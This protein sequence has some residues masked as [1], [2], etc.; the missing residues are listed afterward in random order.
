MVSVMSN[1]I[2]TQ[3][4]NLLLEYFSIYESLVQLKSQCFQLMSSGYYEFDLARH[5]NSHNPNFRIDSS[6]YIGREISPTKLITRKD[7]I[8]QLQNISIDDP[9]DNNNDN[10]NNNNE[11]KNNEKN[12][13]ATGIRKR[14]LN[15]HENTARNIV[16][17][18]EESNN[19]SE[20]DI[21]LELDFRSKPLLWFGLLC[22]AN[23][24]TAQIHFNSALNLLVQI[25]NQQ[26]QLTT[27]QTKITEIRKTNNI[28]Y[29]NL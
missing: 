17:S 21:P 24:K 12:I 6:Y 4:D 14:I 27:I 20:P 2:H 3:L 10:T 25:A 7:E 8:L 1:E 18:D 13:S 23:I 16:D 19:N 22:P 26:N 9:I 29:E 5:N 11:N 15:P 28:Q